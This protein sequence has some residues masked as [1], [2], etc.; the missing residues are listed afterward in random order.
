MKNS[1]AVPWGESAVLIRT[2]TMEMGREIV[3]EGSL[4]QIVDIIANALVSERESFNISLPD[5]HVAPFS[6][7][8][9]I[10]AWLMYARM[11]PA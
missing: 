11:M 9:D 6:Y 4:R 2:G 8:P 10:F 5:R 1:A 7:S 3:A